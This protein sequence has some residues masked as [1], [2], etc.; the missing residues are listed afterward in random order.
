MFKKRN[1]IETSDYAYTKDQEQGYID[2]KIRDLNKPLISIFVSSDDEYRFIGSDWAEYGLVDQIETI[3]TMIR[4]DLANEYDFVVKMHPNQKNIHN[5][6]KERYIKLGHDVDVL[7]PENKT[8]T[9]SL[10]LKSEVVLN[11]CS[12]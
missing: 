9:Y 7:L 12:K 2:E 6:I 1:A 11:F 8:D 4:S 3:Y 5:S 10:I